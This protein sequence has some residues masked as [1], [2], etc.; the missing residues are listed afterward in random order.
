MKFVLIN[1]LGYTS[2][3]ILAKAGK[4]NVRFRVIDTT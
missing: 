3:I 1:R 2:G 4:P